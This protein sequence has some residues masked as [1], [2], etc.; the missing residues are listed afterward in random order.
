MH[1]ADRDGDDL[2]FRFMFGDGTAVVTE[3][4]RVRH[5]YSE[6]GRYRVTVIAYDGDKTDRR[7]IF[8][9]VKRAR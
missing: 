6:R 2:V 7:S 5:T 9:K 8:I 3:K 4:R 1:A